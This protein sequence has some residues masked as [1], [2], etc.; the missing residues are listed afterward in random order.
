MPFGKSSG[1]GLFSDIY[2]DEST[3]DLN[4]S[5][6]KTQ[7]A[8]QMA[9]M[10]MISP[11]SGTFTHSA[12][13]LS[14]RASFPT[15]RLVQILCTRPSLLPLATATESVLGLLYFRHLASS[16]DLTQLL[17]LGISQLAEQKIA[18]GARLRLLVIDSLPPLVAFDE[19]VTSTLLRDRAN[20][21]SDVGL[22]LLSLARK[23]NF[24]VLAVNEVHDV[25]V[26][27]RRERS[28]SSQ[29]RNIGTPWKFRSRDGQADWF[30]RTPERL[31]TSGAVDPNGRKEAKLGL[32]WAYR[33]HARIM[34]TRT[35]RKWTP[36]SER[37][38]IDPELPVHSPTARGTYSGP[39]SAKKRRLDTRSPAPVHT[40][41]NAPVA[42]QQA[43]TEN[44]ETS[45]ITP[46]PISLRDLT[47][48]FSKF[49][50]R[51]SVDFVICASGIETIDGTSNVEDVKAQTMLHDNLSAT[52]I[53]S[54]RDD[55][56]HK[57]L[58]SKTEP[59][60]QRPIRAS[61]PSIPGGHTSAAN[62]ERS[63]TANP[64][65]EIAEDCNP[66]PKPSTSPGK[67]DVDWEFYFPDIYGHSR[68]DDVE[69][70]ELDHD[71][72]AVLDDADALDGVRTPSSQTG[73][74]VDDKGAD[75]ETSCHEAHILSRAGS[76]TSA[77]SLP[78]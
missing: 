56:L 1:R 47:V 62:L 58:A 14:N 15:E 55:A 45:P 20:K 61:S 46:V 29:F 72:E 49:G 57:A 67:N 77:R 60:A 66:D 70:Y 35:N 27:E 65:L 21:L 11:S 25:F 54:Q 63:L 71:E 12:C 28:A 48:L 36:P 38:C 26:P 73:T 18:A 24:A 7:L 31:V 69:E 16:D 3:S 68:N 30:S 53:E 19:Q 78:H 17:E 23:Y 6:G 34:L 13:Y 74:E 8:L 44:N 50:P 75:E 51:A 10:A 59:P 39:T 32:G 41:S 40:V 9:L 42:R 37:A 33:V 2:H 43:A 22:S 52:K 4:S 5:T 76:L 64:Q